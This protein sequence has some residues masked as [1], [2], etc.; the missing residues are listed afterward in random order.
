MITDKVSCIKELTLQGIAVKIDDLA[1]CSSGIRNKEGAA[2]EKEFNLAKNNEGYR[3]RARGT[4][5]FSA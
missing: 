4:G 1:I 3:L 5:E 2:S